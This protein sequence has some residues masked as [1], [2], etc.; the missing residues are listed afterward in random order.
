[1]YCRARS[2]AIVSSAVS[3]CGIISKFSIQLQSQEE[4]V[5]ASGQ[6][7]RDRILIRFKGT[8]NAALEAG[9]FEP[10]VALAA[11]KPSFAGPIAVTSI[12][13]VKLRARCFAVGRAH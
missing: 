1:M 7:L 12:P 6:E 13:V 10:P 8:A 5:L 2:A 9:I 4:F 11:N 3:P